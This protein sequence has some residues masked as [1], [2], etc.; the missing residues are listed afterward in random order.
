MASTRI[1]TLVCYYTL[2]GNSRHIAKAIQQKLDADILELRIKSPYKYKGF[3]KY[4]IG[5]MQVILRSRPPLLP[6]GKDFRDYQL[7]I[8]G[9]PVWAGSYAPAF[10]TLFSSI[11]LK[12]KKI[13]FF[14][15]CGGKAG[16]TFSNFKKVLKG[17]QFL[18]EIEFQEP[19]K[20]DPNGAKE[21]A[22][23]WAQEMLGKAKSDS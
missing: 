19:L 16:K 2:E 17:N 3:L 15:C 13:A 7:I 6:L 18:G 12:K 23:L 22:Q 4:F 1:K 14:A 20:N 21:K 11:E 10:R 8:F 5:G 9:T